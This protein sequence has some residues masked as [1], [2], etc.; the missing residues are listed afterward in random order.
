M[1]NCDKES[2]KSTSSELAQP[3]KGTISQICWFHTFLDASSGQMEVIGF[4][5]SE[6]LSSLSSIRLM[7]PQ[8]LTGSDEK[9][10]CREQLKEIQ[11]RYPDGLPLMDPIEDMHITGYITMNFRTTGFGELYFFSL[12]VSKFLYTSHMFYILILK[13]TSLVYNTEINPH[14]ISAGTFWQ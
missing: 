13:C 10:K 9:R 14:E 5:M 6:C 1:V 8:K 2:I 12:Q 11:R 7:I 3:A 4:S